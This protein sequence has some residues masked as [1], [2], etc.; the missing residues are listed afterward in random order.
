MFIRLNN[1]VNVHS[2]LVLN[3]KQLQEPVIWSKNNR[4]LIFLAELNAK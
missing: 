4:M 3:K 2:R 1:R